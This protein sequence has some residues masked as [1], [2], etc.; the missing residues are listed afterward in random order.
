NAD[1]TLGV[2]TGDG[3]ALTWIGDIL[4][5]AAPTTAAPAPAERLSGLWI[6]A[7]GPVALQV[8]DSRGR[9]TGRAPGQDVARDDIPGTRYERLPGS[10][11]AFVARGQPYDLDIRAERAGSFDLKVRVLGAGRVQRT[12]LYLGVRLGVAGRARLLPPAGALLAGW[13]AL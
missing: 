5:G 6:A 7:L 11:F 13:P 1:Y 3:P 2:R 8:R 10:E 12:A 9:T 4:R